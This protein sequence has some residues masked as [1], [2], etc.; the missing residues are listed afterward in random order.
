MAQ[1]YLYQMEFKRPELVTDTSSWTEADERVGEAHFAYLKA[2]S[3]A[4][5]L[6]VGG[7]SS[8]GVGPAVVIFEAESG[9]EAL[10]F[11]QNDPFVAEGLVEASLHPFRATWK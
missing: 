11:M 3:Q 1:C 6:L 2:A 8:D 9:E 7:R 4:G 10:E 5:R